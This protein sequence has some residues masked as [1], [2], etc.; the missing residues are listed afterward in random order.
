VWNQHSYHVTNIEEDGTIPQHELPNWKQTGLNNFRQNK[1]PGSEFAAPD[2]IVSLQVPC[3]ADEIIAT[4]RNTGEA[5]L[6]ANLEVTFYEGN[7]TTGKKLGTGH[8]TKALYSAQ[9]EQVIIS[10][11]SPS[12]ELASGKTTASATVAVPTDVHECRP[13]NNTSA[14][15]KALCTGPK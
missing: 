8:T 12:A 15:A 11:A 9:A 6:P 4:V 10:L 13:S 5:A 3:G 2:A 7:A 14:P 1:Q